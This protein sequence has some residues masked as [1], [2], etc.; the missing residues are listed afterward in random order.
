MEERTPSGMPAATPNPPT[1]RSGT[2]PLQLQNDVANTE[3]TLAS[4]MPIFLDTRLSKYPNGALIERVKREIAALHTNR[5][6]HFAKVERFARTS[7]QPLL[8]SPPLLENLFYRYLERGPEKRA[9]ISHIRYTDRLSLPE[10]TGLS[11]AWD[12]AP[13]ARFKSQSGDTCT[14]E[15]VLGTSS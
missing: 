14:E 4:P 3:S 7:S 15:V 13:F 2:D 11:L 12:P 8:P 6:T 5:I 10:H 9:P 1:S